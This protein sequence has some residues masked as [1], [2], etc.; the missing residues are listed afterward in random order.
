MFA[1][2]PRAVVDKVYAAAK[3]AITGD[4]SDKDKLIAERKKLI[5]GLK[6]AFGVTDKEILSTIGKAAIEYIDGDDLVTLIGIRTAIKDG[7][8]TVELAFKQPTQAAEKKTTQT[9][10]IKKATA[11]SPDDLKKK[12][13][14]CKNQDELDD[15]YTAKPEA[16]KTQEI[17]DYFQKKK[18]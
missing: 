8:T 16:E 10:K 18:F 3:R 15:L 4:I 11:P 17:L 2:I 13:D 5:D 1:V 9:E 6:D 7:D 12:I 14:A